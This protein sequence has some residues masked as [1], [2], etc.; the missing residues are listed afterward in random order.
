LKKS[1]EL[2]GMG[3]VT[4]EHRFQPRVQLS[5][6]PLQNVGFVAR[7]TAPRACRDSR[8]P[9]CTSIALKVWAAGISAQPIESKFRVWAYNHLLVMARDVDRRAGVGTIVIAPGLAVSLRAR[10]PSAAD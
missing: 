6:I 1:I 10:R 4:P 2:N 5:C 9:A 8:Q 7:T 3:V